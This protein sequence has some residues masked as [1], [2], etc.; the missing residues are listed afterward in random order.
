MEKTICDDCKNNV[1][2]KTFY[3]GTLL[4]CTE[5]VLKCDYIITECTHFKPKAIRKDFEPRKQE[6]LSKGDEP[7]NKKCEHH[8]VSSEIHEDSPQICE[9]CGEEVVINKKGDGFIKVKGST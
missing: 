6:A 2:A 1:R 5:G 9:Q 7:R 8:S 4:S 3:E